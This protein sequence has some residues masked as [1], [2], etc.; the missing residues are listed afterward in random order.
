MSVKPDVLFLD[1]PT[2]GQ[3]RTEVTRLMR[4]LT[5]ASAHGAVVFATH[6]EELA[7]AAAT[8]IVRMDAGRV[9]ES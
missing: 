9:V 4:A 5:A 7:Q 6:D 2:S 3:D 8:R 1:E